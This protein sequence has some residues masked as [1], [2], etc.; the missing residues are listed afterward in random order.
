MEKYKN[1]SSQSTPDNPRKEETQDNFDFEPADQDPNQQQDEK[2][3]KAD[4]PAIPEGTEEPTGSSQ[5]ANK[6]Q[7]QNQNYLT[8]EDLPDA[9][10]ESTGKMGSGQRQDSN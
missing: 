10:N 1:K 6:N 3:W 9:T 8:K 2:V 4:A 5:K 7:Q